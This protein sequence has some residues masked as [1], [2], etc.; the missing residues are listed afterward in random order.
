MEGLHEKAL[1]RRDDN[2]A[3]MELEHALLLHVVEHATDIEAAVVD[4]QGK[5][6]HQDEDFLSTG[7]IDGVVGE[8]TGHAV[9]QRER[10]TP[11]CTMAALLALG[12]QQVEVI[13]PEDENFVKETQHLVL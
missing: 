12:G 11:P 1:E 7:G 2:A 13:K 6:L 8:E 3:P 4:F 5:A 9:G 10:C